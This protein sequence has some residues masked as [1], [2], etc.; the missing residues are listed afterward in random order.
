MGL[1]YECNND[2]NVIGITNCVLKKLD[3]SPLHEMQLTSD[4]VKMVKNL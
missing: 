1:L 4:N 2:I 3:L